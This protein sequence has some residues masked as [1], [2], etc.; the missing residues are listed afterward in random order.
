MKVL[1]KDK[2]GNCYPVEDILIAVQ[3]KVLRTR[4]KYND[5]SD[6][7]D[8]PSVEGDILKRIIA[9]LHRPQP[10]TL[11]LDKA[12]GFLVCD[13]LVASEFLD[14][15][16][17][18]QQIISWM[19]QQFSPGNILDLWIFSKRFLIARL[20]VVCWQ[21]LMKNFDDL[22]TRQLQALDREDLLSLLTSDDLRMNEESVWE[23]VEKL[24]G[25]NDDGTLLKECVRYGLL[26][27]SFLITL[28]FL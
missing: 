22:K 16:L 12:A 27:E 4:F 7:I 9:W 17:L 8:L 10:K 15:S 2:D 23:L 25:P 3:S 1:L 26:E 11:E 5:S 28:F 6:I 13:L 18:S 24:T 19:I 20:E 21:F 14:I